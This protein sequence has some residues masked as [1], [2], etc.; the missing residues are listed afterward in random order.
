MR[1]AAAAA[2]GKDYAPEPGVTLGVAAHTAYMRCA[3]CS[4]CQYYYDKDTHIRAMPMITPL[5]ETRYCRSL[6]T[7]D[8]VVNGRW[9]VLQAKHFPNMKWKYPL[10]VLPMVHPMQLLMSGRCYQLKKNTIDFS[11]IAYSAIAISNGGRP[12]KFLS[13]HHQFGAAMAALMQELT[14]EMKKERLV[15]LGWSFNCISGVRPPVVTHPTKMLC[16]KHARLAWM[17]CWLEERKS[18]C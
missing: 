8:H 10:E 13:D 5:W 11:T 4:R 3:R 18:A 9:T 6:V 14:S 7:D 12:V 1:A 15:Q 16:S 2:A 17:F